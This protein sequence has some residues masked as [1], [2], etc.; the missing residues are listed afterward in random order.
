MTDADKLAQVLAEHVSE[1]HYAG[2][3]YNEP[4]EA[5]VVCS[6]GADIWEWQQF[7]NENP[8][9]PDDAFRAHVAAVVLAHLRPVVTTPEELAALPEGTLFR[10]GDR[11]GRLWAHSASALDGGHVWADK[12]DTLPLEVLA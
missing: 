6:C 7:Y 5:W 3:G 4:R 1:D 10:S 12:H 11:L 2:N 9:D 8:A